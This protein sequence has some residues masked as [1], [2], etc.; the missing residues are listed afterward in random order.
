MLITQAV[1][2]V[3][4]KINFSKLKL[5]PNARVPELRVQDAGAE[6]AD[7]YPLLGDRY[8]LGRSSRTCDIV[9]RN[10][11]CQ[12]GASFIEPEIASDRGFLSQALSSTVL[13]QRREFD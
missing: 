1:Q 7:V 2:T 9:V 4:A 6:Q 10:P 3:Q 11:S 5:K 13:S 12:P 8:V